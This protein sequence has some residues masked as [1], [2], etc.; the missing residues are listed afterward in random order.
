M[1]GAYALRWLR[2]R[3]ALPPAEFDGRRIAGTS[4]W[5][6]HTTVVAGAHMAALRHHACTVGSDSH[7]LTE[8]SV[9]QEQPVVLGVS[10]GG[11][12]SILGKNT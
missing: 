6:G 5:L 7:S 2:H 1:W 12:I 11:F 8:T 10:L 3:H 9:A 4:G